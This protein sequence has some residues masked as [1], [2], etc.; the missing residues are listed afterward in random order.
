MAG[1]D[2]TAGSGDMGD[3]TSANSFPALRGGL[4]SGEVSKVRGHG[5][6]RPF[7]VMLSFSRWEEKE[8]M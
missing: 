1:F 8:R 4:N 5:P 7:H 6:D 3:V 2:G